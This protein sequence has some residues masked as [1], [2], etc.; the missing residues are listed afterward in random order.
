[1]QSAL[2]AGSS[3]ASSLLS[4]AA[5]LIL[6]PLLP[7]VVA[8]TR[9]RLTGRRGQ[10]VWQLYADL[11]KLFRK[12]ALYST[13]TTGM[14]QL[15]GPVMVATTVLACTL[16][17]LDGRGALFRFPG[18]AVAFAYALALGRFVLVLGALDTGSSF[19]GMGASRE[20]TLASLVEPGLF[21]TLVALSVGTR[22]L[23]L[24]G[25]LGAPLWRDWPVVAPAVVL[26]AG[27]VFVLMLAECARVPVDDPHTHLELTMIHEVMV[28]DHAGPDL[29][30]VLYAGALKL[31]LFG[32]L[33]VGLTLPRASLGAGP[34]ALLLVA[35]VVVVA[36]LVG[37]VEAS[38]ARLRLPRVPLYIAS[39]S[40]LGLFGLILLLQ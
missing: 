36:M 30:F 5:L 3:V 2:P 15:S 24:S 14:L 40:A 32:A 18:D 7:G 13:T 16:V 19:E 17:P 39:G 29:G 4:W 27:S 9:A 12:S 34:S 10:P 20:V 28:L 25:M 33:I 21:V 6:A 31:A 26:L 11:A 38:V 35:G 1:M 23:S 8:R 22:D 37:L